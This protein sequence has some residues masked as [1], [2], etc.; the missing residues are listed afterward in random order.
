MKSIFAI[1]QT[2]EFPELFEIHIARGIGNYPCGKYDMTS[3]GAKL[4]VESNPDGFTVTLT[5]DY[6]GLE[7]ED[8]WLSPCLLDHVEAHDYGVT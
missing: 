3:P 7:G 5:V 8:Y 2:P 6:Q 4:L 1:W